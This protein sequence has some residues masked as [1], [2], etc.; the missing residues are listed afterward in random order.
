MALLLLSVNLIEGANQTPDTTPI[1]SED[2][3]PFTIAIEEVPYQLPTGLHSG[4]AGTYRGQWV[5]IAGR[6]N[7]LHGFGVNPFPP[8]QQNTDVYVIDCEKKMTYS[9]SLA[10]PSSGLSQEQI[11]QLSVTSPEYSQRGKT[12]YICG[13]YGIDT[14]TNEFNTKQ[15][16][17]AVDLPKLIKWVKTGKGS[18]S[19]A[20]RQT[21]HPWMQVT[22]GYMALYNNHLQGMLVFGQNFDGVYTPGSNGQYTQQVR[23]FQIIDTGK[24]LSVVPRKSEAPHDEYRRR[25][26]NVVP[27]IKRGKPGYVAL[28]G[29]F[30]LSG[31][32]WTVPVTIALDGSTKMENPDNPNTFKQG[33]NNYVSAT[34]QL[35]TKSD[36]TNYIVQLGGI[37]YGYF[38]NGSFE[39]D[40]EFPFINQVSTIKI[41]KHCKFSQYLMDAEYPVIY[42][43]GTNP[44]NSLIFGAG[45]YYFNDDDVSELINQIIDYDDIKQP[46]TIGYIVGGIMSTVPN[47]S[48]ITDSTASP[49]I[50]RLVITPKK[51]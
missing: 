42:S 32:I 7:G 10:D 24:E 2:L 21:S 39:T 47:T 9:R 30:T 19:A 50:F 41:D 49:Y 29:V 48:T 31:G 36:K 23:N 18:A 26:L 12:L 14:A 22:G 4:A 17:T 37:S 45:A 1:L 8:S 11:D 35:Y 33:M 6:T 15:T 20:I 34:A 5:I 40:D 38:Y 43:Q 16:L 46:T 27:I 25:D 51:G 3:L 44:G 13:G 28:T